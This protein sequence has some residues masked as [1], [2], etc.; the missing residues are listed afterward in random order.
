MM[1]KVRKKKE[2]PIYVKLKDLSPESY[3]YMRERYKPSRLL[4]TGSIEDKE[5]FDNKLNKYIDDFNKPRT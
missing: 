5:M 2:E 3:K 4:F 1:N